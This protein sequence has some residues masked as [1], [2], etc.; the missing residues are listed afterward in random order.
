MILVFTYYSSMAINYILL[1][2]FFLYIIQICNYI[3]NI[4]KY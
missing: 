4:I 1:I 3:K 2:E